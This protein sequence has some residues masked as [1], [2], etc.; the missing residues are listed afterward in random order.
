MSDKIFGMIGLAVRAGKVKFGVYLA[1][2][3]CDAGTAKLVVIPSDLGASNKRAIVGK[4]TN[5]NVPVIEVA[6]KAS[7]SHA[8]GKKD[9]SAIAVCDENF[10]SAIL[11]LHGGGVNG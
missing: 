8:V 10:A 9:V 3:A 7:L 6:D 4:C 1:Q 5:T 2:A 11:K